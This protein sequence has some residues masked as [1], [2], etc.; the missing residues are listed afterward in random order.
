MPSAAVHVLTACSH[1]AHMMNTHTRS[2]DVYAKSINLEMTAL[3]ARC[4]KILW[5]N[6]IY[7]LPS[8]LTR[9]HAARAAMKSLPC[10]WPSQIVCTSSFQ[11]CPAPEE[12]IKQQS[13]QNICI[14]GPHV[15]SL[16]GHTMKM[17]AYETATSG[18]RVAEV[19]W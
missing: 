4:A 8:C 2:A 6:N 3:D 17:R 5:I 1:P 18:S 15:S 13:C 12:M 14:E 9:S 11:I 10:F 19:F 7:S 16:E